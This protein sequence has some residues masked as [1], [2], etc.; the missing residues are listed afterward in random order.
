MGIRGRLGPRR[1]LRKSLCSKG[2]R[3]SAKNLDYFPQ[4]E[5]ISWISLDKL[6][7]I[8]YNEGVR[9]KQR[10]G[11]HMTKK[12]FQI[13]AKSVSLVPVR[14]DRWKLAAMLADNFEAMYPRFDR[15]RFIE[16]CQPK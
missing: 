8:Y 11:K 5:R 15:V 12:D 9:N 1:N 2:L 14:S 3:Q 7:D 4:N 6:V 10:K 13:V 16:A